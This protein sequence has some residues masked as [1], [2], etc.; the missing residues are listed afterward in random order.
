MIR[1][2]PTPYGSAKYIALFETLNREL[3][4]KRVIVGPSRNQQQNYDRAL[5]VVKKSTPLVCSETP[6]LA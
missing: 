5:T 1:S 4:I 6:F 2:R 3:P